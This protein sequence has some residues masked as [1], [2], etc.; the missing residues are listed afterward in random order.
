[1]DVDRLERNIQTPI[2]STLISSGKRSRAYDKSD[3][4]SVYLES[5]VAASTTWGTSRDKN[6][7]LNQLPDS[8]C[9]LYLRIA[10]PPSS[11]LPPTYDT[12][13]FAMKVMLKNLGEKLTPGRSNRVSMLRSCSS[14]LSFNLGTISRA[15][16][17]RLGAMLWD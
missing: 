14:M 11:H 1:L 7:R 15:L 5:A 10:Q 12:I 9:K 8:A 17:S 3:I 4:A 2:S 16:P 13:N 6:T